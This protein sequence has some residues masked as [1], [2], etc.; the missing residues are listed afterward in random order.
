MKAPQLRASLLDICIIIIQAGGHAEK[1][2]HVALWH[3]LGED[4]LGSSSLVGDQKTN[5]ARKICE[6]YLQ[7]CPCVWGTL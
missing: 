1:R 4:L 2:L 5:S 6:Q 3:N 7:N